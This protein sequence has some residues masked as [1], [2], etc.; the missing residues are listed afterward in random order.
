MQNQ[1][2]DRVQRSNYLSLLSGVEPREEKP[3][4]G[5]DNRVAEEQRDSD[6]SSDFPKISASAK[7]DFRHA[8]RRT[9]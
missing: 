5:D 1:V 4:Q 7:Q 9:R 2:S 6:S 3:L 8:P